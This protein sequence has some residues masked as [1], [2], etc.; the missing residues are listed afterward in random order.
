[1]LAVAFGLTLG[2]SSAFGAAP[3]APPTDIAAVVYTYDA[4]ALDEVTIDTGVGRGP[5]VALHNPKTISAVDSGSRGILVRPHE[6]KISSQ[7]A[8]D[9]PL[10]LVHDVSSTG[11]ASEPPQVFNEELSSLPGTGGAAKS[12]DELAHLGQGWRATSFGDEAASFEYHFGKHGVE[13]GVTQEQY[14]QDALNWARKPAGTGKPIQLKDGTEGL[15]Y[16]TPGGGPGGITD[17]G[18]TIITFWYR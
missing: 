13:A 4:P 5:P 9:I 11:R 17:L 6:S 1:M 7:Y 10:L 15:R 16:R 8:Y 12:A 18:G 3:A 14:A 2:G